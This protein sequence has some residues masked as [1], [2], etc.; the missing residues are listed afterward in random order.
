MRF[1]R[2]RYF[3][4]KSRQSTKYIYKCNVYGWHLKY[5]SRRGRPAHAIFQWQCVYTLF[6]R[7]VY[8]SFLR[9]ANA[10]FLR[11]VYAIF[12]WCMRIISEMS[13]RIISEVC[14][15]THYSRED[16]CT[17]YFRSARKHCFSEVCVRIISETVCLSNIS[18]LCV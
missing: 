13:A 16:V 12:V 14:V 11:C 15:T 10:I 9:C 18:G 6:L 2:Q 8:A 5:L 4:I 1:D 7:C 3:K 17:R